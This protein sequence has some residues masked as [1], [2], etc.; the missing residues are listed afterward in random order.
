MDDKVYK[1]ILADDHEIMLDGLSYI[2]ETVANMSIIKYAKNGVELIKYVEEQMPDICLIDLDMPKMNGFKASEILIKKYPNIKIIILSMHKEISLMKR[3]RAMG[4]KGYLL[5]TND[6][7]ELV[8]AINQVL[9]GKTYFSDLLYK[10][11]SFKE[12]SNPSIIEKISL[13][14]KREYEIIR[15]LCEGESNKQIA[16]K[17]CISF[18]TV[19]NH[20]SNIMHKLELH[21]IVELVRF[22]YKNN[23]IDD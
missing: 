19:D 20:R 13:I 18:K 12:D 7:D 6:K 21:N 11:I 1:I 8:F 10:K 22:C 15:L 3:M 14:T 4:I 9:K 5:K 16:D 2:I 23:L 17:L